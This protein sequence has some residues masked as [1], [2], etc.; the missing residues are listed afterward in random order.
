METVPLQVLVVD[1]DPFFLKLF[2]EFLKRDG[3]TVISAVNVFQCLDIIAETSLDII[4]LDLIMPHL[5][6]DDMCRIIR[7]HPHLQDAYVVIISAVALEQPVDFYSFG[8]DACIAKGPFKDTQIHIREVIRESQNPRNEY[9]LQ[10][11]R[12]GENLYSRKITQELLQQIDHLRVILKNMSQGIIEITENRIIYVNSS[13]ADMLNLVVD[14]ILGKDIFKTLPPPLIEIVKKDSGENGIAKHV[15]AKGTVQFNDRQ[16]IVE[17]LSMRGTGAGCVLVLSDVTEKKRMESVIE[18]ANL[19]ENL[20]Y[21]FSGIRHEIG[22]PVNSIK[23]ALSVL[24]RNLDEYD[25]QTVRE[26][27]VR[28]LE[29]ISRIEYLLKALKNYSLF[30]CPVVQAIP[31]GP[32]LRDFVALIRN[33][34]E[35]MHIQISV[36]IADENMM[37]AVDSR[38]FHHVMLNLLTNAADALKE[39]KN[40]RIAITC[41]EKDDMAVIKVDDNGKGIPEGDR[42]HLFKPFF[43]SKATGTGLGLAIVRKMLTAMHGFIAIESY[44][45]VGTT[46]T[47]LLPGSDHG[48]SPEESTDY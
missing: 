12:G 26:F 16:F 18:A 32:F 45:G 24:Q 43:T 44:Q 9:S 46:V 1:N 21:V 15:Q 10:Q 4:F 31:I 7:N 11:L 19:T 39:V 40:P 23:M 37:V 14:D 36:N 22:N 6:G 41:Y 42:H 17:E 38:A 35:Q 28:S 34:F 8:A 47:I 13:G 25:I 5:G 2:E 30:E 29:E 3:H 27:L 20:G 33:D 48:T